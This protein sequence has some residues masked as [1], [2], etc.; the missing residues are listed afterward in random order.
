LSVHNRQMKT[1]STVKFVSVAI[2][3]G[4]MPFS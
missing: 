4:S 1:S 3:L 2:I